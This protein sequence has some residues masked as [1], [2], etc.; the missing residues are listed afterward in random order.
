VE[1][2]S[3]TRASISVGGL[4]INAEQEISWIKQVVSIELIRRKER[5]IA[6]FGA[7]GDISSVVIITKWSDGETG[8][9]VTAGDRGD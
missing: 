9:Q 1:L 4:V 8:E 7:G 2:Y 6:G 3:A 5:E